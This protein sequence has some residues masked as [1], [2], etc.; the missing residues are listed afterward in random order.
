MNTD[1][2]F[3]KT[4]EHLVPLE[5]TKFLVHKQMLSDFRKLQN[6]ATRDGFDLQIVSAFRDHARQLLIWNK[7]ASGEKS[8]QDN[9]GNQI[10]VKAISEFDL[11]LSIL[12]WSA[13]PGTSRHHW[14]SDID[15]FDGR[16]QLRDEVQLTPSECEGNGASADL[17]QWLDIKIQNES[18]YGFFRPYRDDLG[19]VAAERWHLSYYPVSRRMIGNYTFSL[20]KNNIES[21]EILLKDS[22]LEHANEIYS[23]FFLNFTSP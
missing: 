17:H 16:K 2:L 3:G 6:D 20:F 8:V 7:K 18:S 23:R 1:I 22:V 5:G 21:S 12:R 19:G 13:L 11:M 4:T 9:D 15:I 10:D 14:G